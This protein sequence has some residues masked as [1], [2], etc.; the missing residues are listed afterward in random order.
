MIFTTLLLKILPLYFIGLLGFFAGKTFKTDTASVS[1][2]LIYIISPLVFFDF[3]SRA[4]IELKHIGLIGFMCIFSFSMA[5]LGYFVWGRLWTDKTR[6]LLPLS[7]CTANNGY[8][9]LPIA[10]ILFTPDQVAIY[11]LA[12]IGLMIGEVTIGY[13]Y[14]ARGN[15]TSKEAVKK[16]LSLPALY[17]MGLGVLVSFSKFQIPPYVYQSL[18]LFKGA[19]IVLGMMVVGLALSQLEAPKTDWKF[20]MICFVN[21]FV[22]WPLIIFGFIYLDKSH[23]LIFGE[24]THELLV[25]F[26]IVPLAANTVA[27]ASKLNV[28]P[29]KAAAAVLFSTLFALIAIPAYYSFFSLSN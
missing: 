1:K 4:E 2:L 16:L 25:L 8:F 19:Y 3:I 27:Y 9:G 26:S 13:Y 23:F 20:I 29:D 15:Y 24:S 21:K 22:F 6:S 7:C 5:I 10:L 14:L 18:A 28:Y 12:G 17:A 11:A